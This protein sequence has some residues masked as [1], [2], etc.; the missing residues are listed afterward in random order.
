MLRGVHAERC[1]KRIV[2]LTNAGVFD[3]IYASR[4]VNTPNSSFVRFMGW[5]ESTLRISHLLL[6]LRRI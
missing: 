2:Q 5:H 1:A 3:A 4:F 6:G